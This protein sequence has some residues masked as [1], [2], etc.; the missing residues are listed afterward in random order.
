MEVFDLAHIWR[1]RPKKYC[2]A[3]GKGGSSTDGVAA[4]LS[5]RGLLRR[6][7]EHDIR[8]ALAGLLVGLRDNMAVDVCRGTGLGVPQFRCP[9][10]F[11][12]T[13]RQTE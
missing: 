11:G 7:P 9:A 6:S 10:G 8:Q 5:S 1:T 12:H 3:H 2:L 13:L 4:F